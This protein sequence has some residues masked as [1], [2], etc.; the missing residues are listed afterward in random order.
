MGF[1][2]TS[3]RNVLSHY[4]RRELDEKFGS[5]Y[6]TKSAVKM[7]EWTFDYD[8]LPGPG[9]TN[10]QL[11][12]PAN[13]RIVSARF[14]VITAFTS[15]STT[16]D[17]TVGLQQADGTEIDDDGLLAAT[18]LTQTVIADVG[19]LTVGAGALVGD[20]IG[21]VAGELVVTPT[22]ADLLTGRGRVIVEY[23]E[24]AV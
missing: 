22:V 23:V 24:A 4:G 8:D 13:A 12:I 20:T 7:A 19:S 6:G 18:D 9:T 10:L 3:G 21:S 17:L 14:E 2:N 16:T 11:A 5:V 15:T 1:E